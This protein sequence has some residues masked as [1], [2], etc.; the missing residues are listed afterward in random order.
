M[1]VDYYNCKDCG[2][3]WICKSCAETCHRGHQVSTYIL[4]HVP[5]WACCYCAKKGKCKLFSELLNSGAK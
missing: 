5:S 2:Y 4:G 1:T 3:N